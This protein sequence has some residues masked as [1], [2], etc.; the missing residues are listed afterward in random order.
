MD[1]WTI[2]TKRVC[3]AL[4][5]LATKTIFYNAAVTTHPL[6]HCAMTSSPLIFHYFICQ[7]ETQSIYIYIYEI[8]NQQFLLFSLVHTLLML[9]YV[10]LS[11]FCLLHPI[12]SRRIISPKS[13]SI[14][15]YMYI[16]GI[17]ITSRKNEVFYCLKNYIIYN[18]WLYNK[19]PRT[20]KTQ[21]I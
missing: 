12:L 9:L 4:N 7:M 21:N 6:M 2:H 11:P 16:K 14:I 18:M 3:T 15:Y 20:S 17:L 19:D 1:V 5:P 8:L 13:K 10:L